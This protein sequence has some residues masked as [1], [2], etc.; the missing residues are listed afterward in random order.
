MT[1]LQP[2]KQAGEIEV[3]FDAV[4]VTATVQQQHSINKRLRYQHNAV[5]YITH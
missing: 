1:G 2:D 4:F 5:G 3:S